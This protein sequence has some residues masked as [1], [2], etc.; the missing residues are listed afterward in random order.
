MIP[1]TF[2]NDIKLSMRDCILKVLWPK[3]DIVTFFRNNSCTKSDIDALGDHKTLHRYQ[4]V[5]NMFTYLSTKPD[6]GLGQ[7]RAMLQSLVNWQQFDPYYFEKLGKLDKTE[8]ERSIIHLKQLQEIRDHKIQE[9]RKA[10]ARKEA[11]TKVPSTTL[12][13]LKTKFI[14][15]LQSEVIGAKRGY[16]LEEI[17]QSLCK[18]SSLEV[19]EPYRVNGEQIDGSLKYDG[20]HYIIE[21]KWQEKAIANEAVYQFSGKIEGKMYGRGFLFQSTD[22]AKM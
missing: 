22:L 1:M 16:V 20:E 13:E 9:R 17:L 6:E 21:A 15:L 3:D 10:Q 8:A 18:I 2:P 14:S 19:T 4:I 7:Y 5:D 12:P 11:A